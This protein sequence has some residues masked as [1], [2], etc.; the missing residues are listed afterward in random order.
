MT[1]RYGQWSGHPTGDPE[2]LSNCIEEVMN[3]RP[4]TNPSRQCTR[5][6]GHG[7]GG[8]YCK[9]HGRMAEQ[10]ERDRIRRCTEEIP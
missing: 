10:A 7:P 4:Y 8:L 9:Q 2:N 5:K 3:D 6:R 1:R